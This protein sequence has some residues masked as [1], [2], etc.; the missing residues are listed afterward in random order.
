[1]KILATNQSSLVPIRIF[2]IRLAVLLLFSTVSFGQK[3]E[4]FKTKDLVAQCEK[5]MGGQ[6]A[7]NKTRHISWTFFGS[8]TLWWDKNTGDV[9]IENPKDKTVILWNSQT[10][11]GKASVNG[12][13]INAGEDLDKLM[14]K[15]ERTWINDSYWL[16]MPFKLNDPGVNK[17]YLGE[18]ET[19]AGKTA[20]VIE[21]TFN[22]VGVTPQ[23]KYHI[24]FDQDSHLV[25][26]W[27]FYRNASDE[28]P[29]FAMP[30][31]DY[32]PYGKI[33]LS[34]D[35]G[36]RKLSNIMVAQKVDK[37]IYSELTPI[38]F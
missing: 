34:G 6:K 19:A 24:Y 1:M 18:K 28:K 27:D 16:V 9:R 35:R 38:S 17:K 26:Q 37:N 31:Q 36:E 20:D 5:S 12:T 8:R 30:W 11:K 7:Y 25:S 22:E 3:Q 10:S 23:N 21:L 29:G 33:M 14:T 32:Q 13:E 2:I 15:A 4:D